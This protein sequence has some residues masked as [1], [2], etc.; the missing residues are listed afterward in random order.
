MVRKSEMAHDAAWFIAYG[1]RRHVGF[2]VLEQILH[3]STAP[4]ITVLLTV[5]R[6]DYTDGRCVFSASGHLATAHA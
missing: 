6:E 5:R 4:E 3:E 2:V 1:A